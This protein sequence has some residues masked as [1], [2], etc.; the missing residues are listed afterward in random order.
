MKY[1]QEDTQGM[2]KKQ[3]C[4]EKSCRKENVYDV[5]FYTFSFMS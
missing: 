4:L 2:N 3:L 5:P 1:G